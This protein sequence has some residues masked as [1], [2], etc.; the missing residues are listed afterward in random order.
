MDR[1]LPIS[2]RL[3]LRLRLRLRHPSFGGSIVVTDVF[4]SSPSP[5]FASRYGSYLPDQSPLYPSRRNE[6]RAP[7]HHYNDAIPTPSNSTADE[8]EL[9]EFDEFVA[10]FEKDVMELPG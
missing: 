3:C 7:Q 5:P 2:L 9:Q 4:K 6:T 10:E 1:L 8:A